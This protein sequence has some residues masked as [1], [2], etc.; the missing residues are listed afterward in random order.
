MNAVLVVSRAPWKEIE[1]FKKRMGWKFN[2]VSSFNTDFNF[3]F[4]VSFTPEQRKTIDCPED[5]LGAAENFRRRL[6]EDCD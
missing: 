4:N 1:P 3:D 6:L 2:W 5:Y